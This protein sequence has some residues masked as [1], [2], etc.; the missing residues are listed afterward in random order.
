V[1]NFRSSIS[2]KTIPRR[3]PNDVYVLEAADSR[4]MDIERTLINGVNPHVKRVWQEDKSTN[5]SVSPFFEK[6][7]IQRRDLN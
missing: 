3:N 5:K 4:F 7:N 6:R 1:P 2:E